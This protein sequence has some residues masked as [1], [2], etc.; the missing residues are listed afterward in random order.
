MGL[1]SQLERPRPRADVAWEPL[2]ERWYTAVTN[3][4]SSF[5]GFPIG[6]DAALRVAAVFACASLIAETLASLPLH[7][8]RRRPDGGK[9]RA[10]D[11]RLYRTLRF[12]PNSWMTPL[13]FYGSG[14]MHLGLRGNMYYE[15]VDDG[16]SVELLPLHP[17][18]MQVETIRTNR[19]R[20]R[21]HDLDMGERIFPQ[22]AILHIR[23]LPMDGYTGQAR[24]VLAREAIAVAAAAEAFVGGFFKNDATGRLVVS[25]PAKLGPEKRKELR[26][27]IQENYAG[28]ANRS[29][30][31]LADGGVSVDEL[32]RKGGDADF[33]VDPRKFQASDVARFWRVPSF[34]IG[35]E[36]K[37]TAWGT[38]IEQMTLG[39]VT[40][41]MKA[42]TDRWAQAIQHSL[43]AEDEREEYFVEFLFADLLRGDLASRTQALATQKEHGIISANEWRRMENMNPR[44]DG[45]DYQETPAGTAPSRVEATSWD[46][47]VNDAVA[48]I[49][50]AEVREVEK[51]RAKANGDLAKWRT[52]VGKFYGDHREYVTKV[53]VPL[54]DAMGLPSW[55]ADNVGQRI[56][57]TATQQLHDG[58]AEGWPEHRR[59]EVAAVVNETIAAG[60]TV[61]A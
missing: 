5:S 24:A 45:D 4:A 37:N 58:V 2:D 14:Q 60:R 27:M 43:L 46:P 23:D 8:L 15:I 59:T 17:D 49:T 30:A 20:Y 41:T 16:R 34:M 7:L 31:F 19:L 25:H 39:F 40:F 33:I 28:Y 50:A 54:M 13:D 29:K 10:R 48:R 47:L 22:E 26:E 61:A 35:M 1:I 38:G 57:R 21:F 52:W 11:H 18:R 36:E 42:W 32:G 51:R 6:P 12:R 53:M 55:V 3:F 9:E 44:D 56:E